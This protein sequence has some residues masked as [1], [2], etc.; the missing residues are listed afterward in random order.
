VSYKCTFYVC[1]VLI[2][3]GCGGGGGGASSSESQGVT[4]TFTASSYESV[5]DETV[6]VTWNSSG[7]NKCTANSLPRTNFFGDIPLSGSR[8]VVIVQEQLNRLTVNCTGTGANGFKSESVDITGYTVRDI[9]GT[10]YYSPENSQVSASSHHQIGPQAAR[11]FPTGEEVFN[12]LCYSPISDTLANDYGKTLSNILKN[13]DIDADQI[14]DTNLTGPF[15]SAYKNIASS[16]FG[17]DEIPSDQTTLVDNFT[18]DLFLFDLHEQLEKNIDL[19]NDGVADLN[20]T[21]SFNSSYGILSPSEIVIFNIQSDPENSDLILNNI[22]F[23]REI[24]YAEFELLNFDSNYDGVPDLNV[25]T[26][27]DA[28]ADRSID[29]NNDC[30]ADFSVIDGVGVTVAGAEIKL[31]A[32]NI[33]ET[34]E[35]TGFEE[36]RIATTDE[37]GKF[38]F[39][40]VRTGLW[41]RVWI[42]KELENRNIHT[43]RR[44]EVPMDDPVWRMGAF[45][46]TSAPMIMGYEIGINDMSPKGSIVGWPYGGES[47]YFDGSYEWEWNVG[48]KFDLKFLFEDPNKLNIY[49]KVPSTRNADGSRGYA[50]IAAERPETTESGFSEITFEYELRQ[51]GCFNLTL[52]SYSASWNGED[53]YIGDY[54]QTPADDQLTNVFNFI[55]DMTF[56]NSDSR[57]FYNYRDDLRIRFDLRNENR[58]LSRP[59]TGYT[60][61]SVKVNSTTYDHPIEDNLPMWANWSF[62]TSGGCSTNIEAE[63]VNTIDVKINSSKSSTDVEGYLTTF[64]QIDNF[65]GNNAPERVAGDQA[66]FNLEDDILPNYSYDVLGGVCITENEPDGYCRDNQTKNINIFYEPISDKAPSKK[67]DINLIINGENFKGYGC[68]FDNWE[69]CQNFEQIFQV[70]D[71]LTIELYADDPNGLSS[72]FK[73]FTHTGIMSDWRPETTVD[74]YTITEENRGNTINIRYC[75][76]NNDGVAQSWQNIN[77]SPSELDGC[78]SLRLRV[79]E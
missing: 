25:D 47:G 3:Y 72:E 52:N 74:T 40:D 36:D 63:D 46:L 9:E 23:N 60:V 15:N 6:T 77:S 75:W 76:R 45:P 42:R 69:P 68:M 7:A 66:S 35:Y 8:D 2:F 13:V 30:I 10:V 44:F 27:G 16:S 14:P 59:P 26:D 79:S 41:H 67:G 70:G 34:G 57:G 61:E 31:A 53:E 39:E 71:T 48:D 65:E 55:E 19:D 1:S 58:D 33:N 20:I 11:D 4:L 50:Y 5:V 38:I 28:I 49:R 21:R 64:W 51:E 43:I 62:C 24:Q 32:L 17:F 54:C 78:H 22:N 37:E 73:V 18:P 29:S 12:Y 56:N